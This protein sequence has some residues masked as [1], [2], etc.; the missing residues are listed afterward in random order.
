MQLLYFV[1]DLFKE[2]LNAANGLYLSI[3]M[4]KK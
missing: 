4:D 3:N 1:Y 2:N